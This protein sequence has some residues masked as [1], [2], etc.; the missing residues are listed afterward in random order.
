M[1]AT[2]QDI[3]A[4]L[5]LARIVALEAGDLTLKY[6]RGEIAVERKADDSPVTIADREAEQHI[7]SRVAEAFAADGFLGEEFAET[8]GSSG[9][10][11]IVDPI[12][13]TKSFIHGVPLYGTM[14]AVEFAQQAV[15]GVVNLPPLRECAYAGRGQGAW[16]L[17]ENHDPQPMRVSSV[18]RLSEALF[19]HT[20]VGS[21]NALGYADVFNRL[22]SAARLTRTWGDCYG[23]VLVASG[24][25]ELMID[26][27]MNVWDAAALQPILEEAG[28]TFT[29]WQGNPTIHAG[30]G[31]ATNGCVLE[32]VLAITRSAG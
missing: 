21:F 9:F 32:E 5:E 20:D 29:D 18:D 16:L 17:R 27:G 22:E 11:W 15:V 6:F 25:A 19:V 24:R 10:R 8:S 2:P 7:R 3:A 30:Q 4:R 28:G 13:G 31:I 1:D 14:V 12:D 23:Y 26:A